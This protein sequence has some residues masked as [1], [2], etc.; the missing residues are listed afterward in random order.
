[1]GS[2]WNIC[3]LDITTVHSYGQICATTVF[4]SGRH[5]AQSCAF[6][7]LVVADPELGTWFA[8]L[9]VDSASQSRACGPYRAQTNIVPVRAV[10]YLPPKP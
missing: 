1:M 7:N 2:L 5:V 9:I 3:G 10:M 8:L 4:P 6:Q